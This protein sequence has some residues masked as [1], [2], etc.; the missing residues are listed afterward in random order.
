M[1]L[2]YLGVYGRIILKWILKTRCEK[3]VVFESSVIALSFYAITN[4][5]D[6]I[7]KSNVSPHIRKISVSIMTPQIN[8]KAQNDKTVFKTLN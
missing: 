5:P 2:G 1:Q 6:M 8:T 4:P 7:S 3:I